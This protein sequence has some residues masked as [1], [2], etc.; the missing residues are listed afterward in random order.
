MKFGMLA[1]MGAVVVGLPLAAW[2]ADGGGVQVKDSWTRATA[3]ESPNGAVFMTLTDVSGRGDT[4]V[5]VESSVSTTTELHVHTG[6]GGVMQMH[7]VE[8]LPVPAGGSVT[9]K[10]GAEH[11]MLMGL[12]QPLKEGDAIPL[13]L[14]FANAGKVNTSAKVWGVGAM[15]PADSPHSPSGHEDDAPQHGGYQ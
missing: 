8:S 13:T 1:A 6:I 10:P 15:E 12:K 14:T 11:V 5:A 7:P 2:A 9:L 3:G 4:L